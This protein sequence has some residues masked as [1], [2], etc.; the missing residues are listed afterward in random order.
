MYHLLIVSHLDD[1]EDLVLAMPIYNLLDHISNYYE[2]TKSLWFYSKNEATDFN[3]DIA[4]ENNFKLFTYKTSFL[5]ITEAD[6]ANG[7]F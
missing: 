4:N 6:N 1:A 5:G 2:T 3:L 7:S